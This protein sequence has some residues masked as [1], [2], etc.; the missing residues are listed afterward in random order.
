MDDTKKPY[1]NYTKVIDQE[2]IPHYDVKLGSEELRQVTEVINS[3]WLS[4]GKK[5]R[6]FEDKFCK[7][8]GTKYAFATANCTGGLMIALRAVGVK[9]DDEVIVPT[10]THMGSVSCI[11]LIGSIPIFVDINSQS[12]TVDPKGIE[13]AI[14]PRTKAI[15]AVHL[16]GH[17]ADM[18]SIMEISKKHNIPVIEDC[19]PA[20]GSK[21]HSTHVGNFGSAGG[22][23]FFADKTITTGEG[24]MLVTNDPEIGKEILMLKNDGRIERGEYVSK[25]MGYNFRITDLQSS[26]ALPQ[27]DN[28]TELVSRKRKIVSLY[29]KFLDGSKGVEFPV[30]DKECFVNPHRA[31]IIVD[32]PESLINF[33]LENNMGARRFFYPVHRYPIYKIEQQFPNTEFVYEHGLSL[34][35]S[36][37]L[38]ENAIQ[39]VCSKVKE[40]MNL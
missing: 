23:S 15:I 25:R 2:K 9:K 31:N 22:F 5:T 16:Y 13:N 18:D 30:W 35:S 7:L 1:L 4:E 29:E 21:Y 3:N 39:K 36:P 12:F 8:V 27:L 20:V 6:E 17:P 33:L 10:F 38:D 32:D 11:G 28:L 24:G 37:L 26:I 14:T 34:P 40:F 19:A